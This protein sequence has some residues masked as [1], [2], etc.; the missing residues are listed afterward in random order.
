MKIKFLSLF[1][2]AVM[3]LT[4]LASCSSEPDLSA[5][6]PFNLE[7]KYSAE[8]EGVAMTIY[9]DCNVET[10][11][12][13]SENAPFKT[14][15]EAQ[16]KIVEMKTSEAG[17]P[18]GGI[19]V[20][21]ASGSYEPFTVSAENSGDENCTIYYVS[22][23][24][25]GA[26]ITPSTS[27][28]SSDF[29]ALN[30][31]EKAR[32]DDSSLADKIVKVDLK[33]YGLTVNEWGD[34]YCQGVYNM[35]PFHEGTSGP[36]PSDV[37]FNG[38]SMVLARYPNNGEWLLTGTILDAGTNTKMPNFSEIQDYGATFT[39]PDELAEKASKWDTLDDVWT[40]GFFLYN[41]ADAS[42]PLASVDHANKTLTLAHGTWYGIEANKMY[43]IFNVFEEMDVPGEYYID[44]ENGIL[45]MYPLSDMETARITIGCSYTN[46][47]SGSGEYI[48]VRGFFCGETRGNIVGLSNSNHITFENCS[49]KGSIGGGFWTSNMKNFT[50][51]NCEIAHTGH[52][53][54]LVNNKEYIK[55][56]E[57][58]N[59][60]IYNNYIHHY[61]EKDGTAGGGLQIQSPYS[62]ISHNE[63]C[64]ATFIAISWDGPYNVIEYNEIYNVCNTSSDAGAINT[65]RLFT[66]YGTEIR[67][68]Y[69][70]D[71]GNNI[72]PGVTC[73]GIYWDDGMSG[74]IAYGN[75]IENVK[76][77]GFLVGGGRD[78]KIY[79]NIMINCT[80]NAVYY[81]N[82]VRDGQFGG[83][84]SW[85][86]NIASRGATYT[87][88][89]D[90]CSNEYW[91]N[92]FPE[93]S[94]LIIDPNATDV[95]D[96]MGV[97][98]P[99]GSVISK[100][101]HY[102]TIENGWDPPFYLASAVQRFA[103]HGD[104]YV[105]EGLTDF[106][107]YIQSEYRLKENSE[108]KSLI[109]DFEI[110]PFDEIGR[111]IE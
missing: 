17:L 67:Y 8:I 73:V 38:E 106:P 53:A 63:I 7:H 56:F 30:A 74:Q 95:E 80:Q 28:S 3:A 14:I 100:N 41:W 88:I 36:D 84:A 37:Y 9:V 69:I 91:V 31:E 16:A 76:G 46:P 90:I 60:K 6:L 65:G 75:I 35:G 107:G 68:N 82:R 110:I 33:K 20:L 12:D 2:A 58:C 83:E 40:Y 85:Y 98:N 39:I 47:I 5:L 104:N 77:F 19:R 50:I 61:L 99:A 105:I 49:I 66:S 109:P 101:V 54:I 71:I 97:W 15:P 57:N 22:E 79:N 27:L 87:D 1:L 92:H 24:E 23:D 43:Y 93:L 59:V 51:Q 42:N 48:T 78:N 11:G 94:K 10:T 86:G 89:K 52:H 96:P 13:G 26:V 81:D 4:V 108:L 102:L 44:R 32:F 103:E 111:V 29:E 45:Y 21:V 18:D 55:T 62:V 25:F 72:V 70:H 64:D 34:L